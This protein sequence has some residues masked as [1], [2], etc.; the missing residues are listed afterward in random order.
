MQRGAESYVKKQVKINL[1]QA[2]STRWWI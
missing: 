1:D 2:S